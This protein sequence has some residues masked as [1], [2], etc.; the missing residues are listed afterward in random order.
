MFAG[1]PAFFPCSTLCVDA[2]ADK[3]CTRG[4]A[5]AVK[6]GIQAKGV[7]CRSQGKGHRHI[8][9][10]LQ[11]V[12]PH[13]ISLR[14][15]SE[16]LQDAVQHYFIQLGWCAVLSCPLDHF[17]WCDETLLHTCKTAFL[18]KH[19]FIACIAILCNA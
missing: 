17:V 10:Q 5:E 11:P 16:P 6:S 13:A 1:L 8:G 4:M 12:Q 18:C 7:L 9:C 14:H 19:A 2:L 15:D 3:Q